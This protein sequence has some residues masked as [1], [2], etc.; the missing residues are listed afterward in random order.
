MRSDLISC[1]PCPCAAL[2]VQFVNDAI[3][4]T[5]PGSL[6]WDMQQRRVGP[7]AEGNFMPYPGSIRGA[8]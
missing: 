3:G 6:R 2:Q 7:T 4:K 1:S 5:Q 8:A